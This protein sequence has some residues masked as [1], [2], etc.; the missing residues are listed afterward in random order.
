MKGV[1]RILKDES[2]VALVMVLLI[3]TLLSAV[4]AQFAYSMRVEGG[5]LRNFKDGA[6]A[7]Y[8]AVA[9]V[10]KGLSEISGDYD[11]VIRD[12]GGRVVFAE[13]EDGSVKV[14][15][16]NREFSLKAG[17][18]SY[19]IED[20]KGKL[21]V[22]GAKRDTIEDLLRLM[23]VEKT[24]RDIIADS[25]EDW[26]DENHEFHL[27]GA[28]DDYYSA[29]AAP[30]GSKDDLLDSIE[31]LLLV[32]GITPALFYGKKDAQEAGAQGLADLLTVRGDEK[33]NINTADEIVLGAVLGQGK[34]QEIMLRRTTEGYFDKPAFA[35]TTTSDTFAIYSRGEAN[36]IEAAI[37]VIA[38]RKPGIGV[39][40]SYWNEE[41][42]WARR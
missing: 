28:E 8:L 33:I 25:I 35:G 1:S 14:I 16:A 40:I 9:G 32:R 27:N 29:F 41:G 24:Q 12:P 39:K 42:D 5:A 19:M 23:G 26:K 2:G 17:K 31:E 38:E 18:V 15:E 34:A 11:L 10:Q 37:K 7:Y 30:H 22:N 20:E 21:N 4:G 3:L 6:A 36:G 13:R